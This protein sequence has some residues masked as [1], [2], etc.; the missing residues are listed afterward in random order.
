MATPAKSIANERFKNMFDLLNTA[1]GSGIITRIA[2]NTGSNA[3]TGTG[4]GYWDQANTF[5]SNAW[6]LF[7]F[8]STA[9][10]SWDWYMLIQLASGSGNFGDAP[11]NPGLINGVAEI[12]GSNEGSI[13]IAAAVMVNSAGSSVSPWNG[14][15]NDDGNDNKGDPVWDTVSAGDVLNILPRSNSPDGDHA[16][17][18]ENMAEIYNSTTSATILTSHMSIS[19]FGFIMVSSTAV[20]GTSAI[21]L[22]GEYTPHRYLS[23]F[24]PTPLVMIAADAD[25]IGLPTPATVIGA[26]NGNKAVEGG[27]TTTSGSMSLTVGAD[28]TTQYKITDYKTPSKFQSS[29]ATFDEQPLAFFIVDDSTNVFSSIG[30]LN[31]N[32]IR[33]TNGCGLGLVGTDGTRATFGNASGI[34]VLKFT[35]PWHASARPP[36]AH[37]SREGEDF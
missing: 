27:I 8:D 34:R 35:M 29:V 6:A 19:E 1:T 28:T 33:L 18:R 21:T 31:A 36:N 14:T 13:G 2:H 20:A 22:V 17:S 5:G 11:G 15:T 10:R 23:S 25:G 37:K 12:L 7:R 24:I 26:S 3:G 32:L 4:T 16:S 30:H 9:D